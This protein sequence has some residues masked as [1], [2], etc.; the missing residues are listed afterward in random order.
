MEIVRSVCSL[1]LNL[2]EEN[3]LKLRQP[4]QKAYAN[5]Q[6]PKLLE[7][8]KEELNVKEVEFVKNSKDLP[9][10]VVLKEENSNLIALDINLTDELK[11]EGLFNDFG[12]ALQNLRKENGCK[13]GEEVTF[14]YASDSEVFEKFAKNI[15]KE[16][17]V[18]LEKVANISD[19]K[20]VKL[21][22][23]EIVLKIV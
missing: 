21:N 1:G 17:S 9:K 8:V 3:R 5:I 16:Y 13:V 22:D 18:K 14:E 11:E 4:L 19:G 23:L 20:L 7:I 12:R 2:R 6:N 15:L 10:G